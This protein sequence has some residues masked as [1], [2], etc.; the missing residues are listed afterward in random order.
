[1]S[2]ILQGHF[3]QY[4]SLLKCTLELD[5][6]MPQLLEARTVLSR[7]PKFDS[8]HPCQM[9]ITTC[10]SN[11]AV[12]IYSHTERHTFI[13]IIKNDEQ[14]C[15]NWAWELSQLL[16]NFSH[17]M[18]SGFGLQYFWFKNEVH[19]STG[20]QLQARGGKDRSIPRVHWAA[21]PTWQVSG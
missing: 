10:K 20:L 9:L 7:R 5:R 2:R 16:V 4:R 11:S 6:E 13:Y 18:R 12:C 21:L 3:P 17:S 14:K 15:Q 19:N 8:Q 1:M